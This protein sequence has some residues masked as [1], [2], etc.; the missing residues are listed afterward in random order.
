MKA[1]TGGRRNLIGCALLI[2][3]G[4]VSTGVGLGALRAGRTGTPSTG[5]TVCSATPASPPLGVYAGAASPSGVTSFADATGT[6][7]TLA[8]DY[9]PGNAGFAGMS[10]GQELSWLLDPWRGSGCTLVLGVPMIPTDSSG[11]ASGTLA[12]G[13]TGAYDGSFTTLARTLVGAGFGDAILR[14]GWEFD[15]SWFPWSVSNAT[16]ATDFAR[17]WQQIVTA[18]RGVPGAAFR[19]DWNP[20]GGPTSWNIDQAYPG[21]A[22]VDYVG[23][24]P[25]DQSSST[26]LTPQGSWKSLMTG[27]EGLD[28]LARFGAAHGKPLTLPEWGLSLQS[29][30]Q[31]LGDDPFFINQMSSW[32]HSHSVAFTSYFDVDPGSGEYHAITG[33]NFPSA[34]LAFRADFGAAT[35]SPARFA[36]GT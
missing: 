23:L 34:L 32:I 14:L 7:V 1:A 25:Y 20:I 6:R 3:V 17:Y 30:G 5:G 10:D 19:F 31:G 16:Q 35:T 26:P 27:P 28:W 29:D 4:L 2:A 12:A 11:A 15:G 21:D 22:Y 8:S 33:G 9:L 18:M 36:P 13:A 24:D